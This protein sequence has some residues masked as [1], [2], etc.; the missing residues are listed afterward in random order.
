MVISTQEA[1]EMRNTMKKTE[2]AISE[3][4][5]TKDN[6]VLLFRTNGESSQYQTTFQDF[7][8]IILCKESLAEYLGPTMQALLNSSE[9]LTDLQTL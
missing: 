2:E 1:D 6:I 5:W 7:N 9:R 4:G 3:F 8:T